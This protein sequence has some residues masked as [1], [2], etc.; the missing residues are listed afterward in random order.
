[1]LVQPDI[2]KDFFG[3]DVE[4]WE[5]K[6]NESFLVFDSSGRGIFA[7]EPLIPVLPDP[8]DELKRANSIDLGV[9]PLARAVHTPLELGARDAECVK[10]GTLLITV[11][12]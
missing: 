4:L 11:P 3:R 7:S 9:E 1:M 10:E 12:E 2:L 6:L 5:Q 8:H